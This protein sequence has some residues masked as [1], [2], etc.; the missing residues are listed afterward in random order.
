LIIGNRGGTNVGGALESAATHLPV[1]VRLMES[2]LAMEA[3]PWIRRVN[4][5]LRGRRPTHLARFSEE[6][7]RE[8]REW[9]PDVLVATGLAPLERSAL[10]RIK[11]VGTRLVNYLTDDPWNSAHRAKWFLEALP[12]YDVVFSPRRLPIDDIRKAGARCVQ[13][14]PFAYCP[15]LHF[16]ENGPPKTRVDDI[17]FSGGADRDRVPV[18]QAVIRSGVRLGLYGSLWERFP[19]TR[20]HTRGQADIQTLR[21]AHSTAKVALCLVRRANRD[22]HT[23]RTFEVAAMRSCMLA[24][25]TEEH[26]EIL[27]AD[28]EAVVYFRSEAEM[29]ERM[30]WLLDRDEERV[31]LGAALHARITGGRNTYRDRLETML[32]VAAAS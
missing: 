14:L 25:H 8:C 7:V 22:G 3:S 15:Q 10:Q 11:G 13:F 23:M 27:G 21:Y 5:W 18:I 32:A 24:E 1:E 16:P 12:A 4:W 28:G 2:R 26:E 19:E 30:R 31:R 20:A 17:V 6:V 29:I 9:R